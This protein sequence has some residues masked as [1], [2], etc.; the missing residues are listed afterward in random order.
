M[1]LKIQKANEKL[2]SMNFVISQIKGCTMYLDLHKYVDVEKCTLSEQWILIREAKNA[3]TYIFR[4]FD[5][6]D[7]INTPLG[8]IKNPF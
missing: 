1:K 8:H 5:D 2:Q 3:G 6:I 7:I 4:H